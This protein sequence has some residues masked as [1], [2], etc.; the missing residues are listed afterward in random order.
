MDPQGIVRCIG[1]GW[2][3]WK[4]WS[5]RAF[6]ATSGPEWYHRRN[7]GSDRSYRS[8]RTQQVLQGATGPSGTS[9]PQG[10]VGPSGTSGATGITGPD[11]CLRELPEPSGTLGNC[12]TQL[13]L[14]GPSGTS[15][16]TG[17][18]QGQQDQAAQQVRQGQRV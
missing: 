5:R 4:D 1:D 15:G 10:I 8:N 16:P 7:F 12:R 18:L 6:G 2:S 17:A 11:R 9:G 13:E 14:T 3:N